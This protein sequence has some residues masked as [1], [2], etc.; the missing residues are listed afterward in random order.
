[1]LVKVLLAPPARA[2]QG[3]RSRFLRGSYIPLGCSPAVFFFTSTRCASRKW[4]RARKAPFT[5]QLKYEHALEEAADAIV[6]GKGGVHG[7]QCVGCG[8]RFAA[9]GARGARWG[10]GRGGA[11]PLW[12]GS[13][14]A[15]K[16]APHLATPS[17]SPDFLAADRVG[18]GAP[19]AGSAT[20]RMTVGPFAPAPR[21]FRTKTAPFLTSRP[22]L[23]PPFPL[24]RPPLPP[25]RRPDNV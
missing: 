18:H 21:P 17:E 19:P 2:L 20:K 15:R 16:V 25:R 1:M 11:A 22:P 14:G 24:F 6:A 3:L 10:G 13:G 23:R 12:G 9:T 8:G 7:A 5:R 4:M